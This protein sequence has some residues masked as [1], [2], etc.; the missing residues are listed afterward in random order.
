MSDSRNRATSHCTF[1][2]HTVSV[3]VCKVQPRFYRPEG[4]V[5]VLGFKIAKQETPGIVYRHML[6]VRNHTGYTGRREKIVSPN[7]I[8]RL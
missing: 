6:V 8:R 3:S 1:C 4:F 2:E 5:K 7:I